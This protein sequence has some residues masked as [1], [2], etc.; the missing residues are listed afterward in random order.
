MTQAS[1]STSQAEI[2]TREGVF[3]VALR[4]YD[5]ARNLINKHWLGFDNG[6]CARTKPVLERSRSLVFEVWLNKPRTGSLYVYLGGNL[7]NDFLWEDNLMIELRHEGYS[8]DG[9]WTKWCARPENK[10]V[11]K[12]RKQFWCAARATITLC[13]DRCK[14]ILLANGSPASTRIELG[15]DEAYE[16]VYESILEE[17]TRSHTPAHLANPFERYLDFEDIRQSS[18][19]SLAYELY[20]RLIAILPDLEVV[21]RNIIYRPST[22]LAPHLEYFEYGEAELEGA[23]HQL[24]AALQIYTVY[25]TMYFQSKILP[26]AFT[27]VCVKMSP[28]S[29]ANRYVLRIIKRVKSLIEFVEQHLKEEE[30]QLKE[31]N[32]HHQLALMGLKEIK[33]RFSSYE[34]RFP[35]VQTWAEF[36]VDATTSTVLN[37]DMRYANLRRLAQ[38]LDQALRHIDQSQIPFEVHAFQKLYEQ[39]CFFKIVKALLKLGFEYER[40]GDIRST[41]FYHHPIPNEI[42]CTLYHSALKAKRLEIWYDRAYQVLRYNTDAFDMKRPYGL[43][44]RSIALNPHPSFKNRPDIVLEFHD[45]NTTDRPLIITLDPTLKG[46]V[47]SADSEDED[48]EKKYDYLQTIRSFIEVDPNTRE[49][50]KLVKAAWG[51]WP[52]KL[53]DKKPYTLAENDFELGFIHLRR[54]NSLEAALSQTLSKILAYTGIRLDQDY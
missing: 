3:R 31:T 21:L 37:Y 42:N 34:G 2:P 13:S 12:I 24:Q 15:Y 36:A 51:I 25:D 10:D 9:L 40:G 39:W 35:P 26:R 54:D 14:P 19:G 29:V 1:L 8:E 33:L 45:E 11:N 28:N 32:P 30:N 17:M 46:P 4:E 41:L 47:M 6:D 48:R 23:L 16:K 27:A 49:S 52:G 20:K 43:E 44:K 7:Y 18:N 53:N 50:L 38:L 5:P 22:Q